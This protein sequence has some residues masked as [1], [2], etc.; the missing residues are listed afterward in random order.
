MSL[1][2]EDK[3]RSGERCKRGVVGTDFFMDS[4]STNCTTFDHNGL[5]GDDRGGIAYGNNHLYYTGDSRTLK[6]NTAFNSRTDVNQRD[7]LLSDLLTE[8]VYHLGRDGSLISGNNSTFNQFIKLD[9]NLSPTNTVI[10]LSQAITTGNNNNNGIFPGYGE[11]VFFFS[12]TYYAVNFPTGVVETFPGGIDSPQFC[13]NWAYWG[14]LSVLM[15]FVMYPMHVV[16]Q[17]LFAMMLKQEI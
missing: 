8:E 10:N 2:A 11:V 4:L 1:I 15:G 6:I 7:G 13:E 16:V 9:E 14:F 17:R 5:T 3:Y 12:N